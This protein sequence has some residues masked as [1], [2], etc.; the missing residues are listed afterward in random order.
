MRRHVPEREV[1][2][3]KN[4]KMEY[5]SKG[6]KQLIDSVLSCKAPDFTGLLN[7]KKYTPWIAF[8]LAALLFSNT[9]FWVNV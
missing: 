8:Y 9:G 3:G 4:Y 6:E 7:R 2:V 5:Q 1:S